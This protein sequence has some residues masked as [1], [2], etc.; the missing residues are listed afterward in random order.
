[1]SKDRARPFSRKHR[2][3][4]ITITG[5]MVLIGV[6]NLA[7]GLCSYE[8]PPPPPEP[9]VPV[10]PPPSEAPAEPGSI[11]LADVPAEIMRAFVA[12]HPRTIPRG[13]KK[14]TAPD[15]ATHYEL[16]FGADAPLTRARFLEDGTPVAP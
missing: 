10:L 16:S 4:W 13:A 3:Y 15:G 2:K 14:L 9:I 11:P 1:M 12:A 6:L 5:G 7:L 8:A